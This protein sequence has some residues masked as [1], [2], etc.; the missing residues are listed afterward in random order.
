V[1]WNGFE[2]WCSRPEDPESPEAPI[3]CKQSATPGN[4]K[5]TPGKDTVPR[6]SCQLGGEYL[7]TGLYRWAATYYWTK[8]EREYESY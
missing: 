6:E 3:L 7:G 1:C 8:Q 2:K 4:M 5:G